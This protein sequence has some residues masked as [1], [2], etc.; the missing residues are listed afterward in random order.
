MTLV[1]NSSSSLAAAADYL[2]YTSTSGGLGSGTISGPSGY[3]TIFLRT[4]RHRFEMYSSEFIIL[5]PTTV[6]IHVHDIFSDCMKARCMKAR[7]DG[8]NRALG[9]TVKEVTY[10]ADG[11]GANTNLTLT[12]SLLEAAS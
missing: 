8:T 6:Q 11:L 4:H 7:Q 9:Y 2:S 5:P 10:L 3:E 12:K 1:I